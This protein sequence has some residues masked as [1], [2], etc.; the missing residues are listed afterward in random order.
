MTFGELFREAVRRLEAE[1]IEDAAYDA[2]LLLE[3]AGGPDRAHFPLMR[4]EEAGREVTFLFDAF[5]GCRANHVPLQHILGEA[6]FMGLPFAVNESV[7]IPRA[8]TET[9]VE[10]VERDLVRR[11]EGM[12]L[13]DMCTG[14]GCIGLSLARRNAF[15]SVVLSD[16]SAEALEVA[17]ENRDSLGLKD[18]VK[19]AEGDLADAIL[20]HGEAR[21]RDLRFD[22]ITCNPPYIPRA[23]IDELMP[24][25]RDHDPLLALDGGE[26]GLDFYRRLSG[27]LKPLFKPG[28]RLYLEIGC[29]QAED[30]AGLL[31]DG[32][33]TEIKVLKDLA[34]L[35]RV[36][37]AVYG[38]RS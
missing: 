23:E 15:S 25:V 34:G 29:E 11:G 8:D 36:V 7:L 9:L 18:R 10:A 22:I 26:D 5:V 31:S 14:S 21:L 2:S 27:E 37:T 17:G 33:F 3:K 28:G 1:D 16:L 30:V 32:G 12:S 4:Q 13:L 6:W 20:E 38:I 19:L 35:D 24:E